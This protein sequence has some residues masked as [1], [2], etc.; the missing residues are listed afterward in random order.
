[1]VNN[2]T[3]NNEMSKHHILNLWKQKQ[4]NRNIWC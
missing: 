2:S 4:K 1:M 3:N